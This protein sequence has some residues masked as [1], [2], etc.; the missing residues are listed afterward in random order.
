LTVGA[1]VLGE[2]GACA[3]GAASRAADGGV[4]AALDCARAASGLQASPEPMAAA[5]A[6]ARMV[7]EAVIVVSYPWVR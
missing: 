5:A 6:N 3:I 4:G 1:P 7:R 2:V